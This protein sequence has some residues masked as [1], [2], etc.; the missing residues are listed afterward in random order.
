MYNTTA[1]LSSTFSVLWHI[2]EEP[3]NWVMYVD[4]TMGLYLRLCSY[5]SV[6][7]TKTSRRTVY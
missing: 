3:D 5:V 4:Y 7:T 1:L 6:S 2:S